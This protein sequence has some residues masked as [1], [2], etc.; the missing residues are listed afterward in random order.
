LRRIAGVGSGES[1]ARIS[2]AL[3]AKVGMYD[4]CGAGI[5]LGCCVGA[6]VCTAA[7]GRPVGLFVGWCVSIAIVGSY[8]VVVGAYVSA[9]AVG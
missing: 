8:V 9:A 5:A 3:G 6:I 7:L 1:R 4:G 2:A